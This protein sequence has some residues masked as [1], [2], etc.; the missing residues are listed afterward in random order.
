VSCAVKATVSR[1]VALVRTSPKQPVRTYERRFL[2]FISAHR[3][4]LVELRPEAR[5]DRLIV[6]EYIAWRRRSCGYGMVAVDLD[7]LR[8][9]VEVDLPGV[10]W[11]WLLT[12]TK[13]I[14]AAAPRKPRK[15]HLVTSEQLYALG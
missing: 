15:Y 6:A 13:R 7:C 8:G 3:Q 2:A 11:S 14:R 5:V 10:D 9:A 1:D 12:L 4:D